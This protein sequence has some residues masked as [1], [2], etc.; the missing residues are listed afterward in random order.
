[1]VASPG[2]IWL[3]FVDMDIYSSPPPLGSLVSSFALFRVPVHSCAHRSSGIP[4]PMGREGARNLD[5]ANGIERGCCHPAI[6]AFPS[7]WRL[8]LGMR[9]E[10]LDSA[11]S[12]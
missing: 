10:K 3:W 5:C 11:P 2:Q 8:A 4:V 12:S 9:L 1:M 7:G 6:Q